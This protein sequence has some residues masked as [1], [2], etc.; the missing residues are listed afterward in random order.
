MSSKI[1]ASIFQMAVSE[2]PEENLAKALIHMNNAAK[3]GA[4]I[5][6]LPEIFHCPYDVKIFREEALT[7]DSHL[8]QTLREASKEHNLVLVAGSVVE[9][10]EDHLYNT[11]FVFEKGELLGK[12]RKVHLFDIDLPGMSFQ[13][14]S[15]FQA[16]DK[17]TVIDTSLG[18]IGVAI[19][20]DLRFPELIKTMAL[21]GAE[22]I[23]APAAFNTVTG[24]LHWDI[25]LQSR[26]LDSQ[27]YLLVCSPALNENY[28]YHAYGHSAIID[29]M[30]Q[31]VKMIDSEE[32]TILEEIDLE[33]VKDTRQRLPLISQSQF[34]LSL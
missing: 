27:C 21:H 28:S 13:E 29:P 17:A 26:A 10:A 1:K 7:L 34:K 12:H 15:T 3:A 2:N 30:G 5:V 14:S 31:I 4:N 32:G 8:L 24:P 23:V 9:K 16:G 25:V 11:S 18:K 33:M 20:F 19:C 22:I 6:I